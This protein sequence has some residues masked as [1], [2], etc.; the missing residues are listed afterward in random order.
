M[1]KDK[2]LRGLISLKKRLDRQKKD[3]YGDRCDGSSHYGRF[4]RDVSDVVP[5]LCTI[6]R[7]SL[8]E[9]SNYGI[10][11]LVR[12]ETVVFAYLDL[13]GQAPERMSNSLSLT[14]SE[15]RSTCR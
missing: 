4:D 6:S 14:H 7:L 13:T 2:H 5:S 15:A 10:K 11:V 12:S 8:V 3:S 9:E 1:V